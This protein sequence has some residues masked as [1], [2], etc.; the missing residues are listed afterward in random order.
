MSKNV[1][2]FLLKRVSIVMTVITIVAF[3][4]IP[5]SAAVNGNLTFW[6]GA[7]YTYKYTYGSTESTAEENNMYFYGYIN[8]QTGPN[9]GNTVRYQSPFYTNTSY[10]MFRVYPGSVKGSSLF[11]YYVD[12]NLR[13]TS[14]AWW[15][16]DF[17]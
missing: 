1:N 3:L 16:F 7:N 13:H 6:H 11:E 15:N 2:Q 5:V 14:T 4:V 17:R 9:I 8:Y 12:G 10:R